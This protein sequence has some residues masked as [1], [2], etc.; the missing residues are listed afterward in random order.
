[1]DVIKEFY[2]NGNSLLVVFMM[3]ILLILSLP[4]PSSW[5][6]GVGR[7]MDPQLQEEYCKNFT[8]GNGRTEFFSPGFPRNY[9]AGIKCF[10]TI[11]ADYG[12]FV[13]VD[14]RDY[15]NIEPPTNEGHCDYDYL[16][17]R[18]GDQGYSPLINKFCGSNFPPIITSSGESLW[19]RFV[20]DGTIEYNGF[21]AVYTFIPNPLENIP[22][23]S[24]CEFEI[25]G[26]T[27]YIGSSNISEE[28]INHSKTHGVP[29]DCTWIIRAEKSK[30]IYLQFPHY[31]L[32]MPNDCNYNFIQVFDGNTEVEDM[33]HNF[34]GSVAEN[35]VS[36]SDVLYVRFVGD[37]KGI[38]SE[39]VAVFTE[40]LKIDDN[41]ECPEHSYDCDDTYCIDES[42]LCNGVRNCRFG[43]DEESC[44]DG[45]DSIPLDM[46]APHVISIMLLLI[47][48]MIG[49][50]A[51]MIYNLHRKLTVDK[52][53]IIA[54]RKSLASL[55]DSRAT[56]DEAPSPPKSRASGRLTAEDLNAC[57]VPAP[58]G[59]GFPF[60]SRS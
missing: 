39:F 22:F 8:Y 26:P 48:I 50:C 51:G 46:T 53:D 18:D 10:R 34:C 17:I 11:S 41:E 25:G 32:Q 36:E 23:I 20:S 19:L 7:A 38:E 57:Y 27:D 21:R 24:K 59:G 28:H 4:L 1:M 15:F 9:P 49:M 5:A 6:G 12:Y 47:V 56:L 60:N 45:G 55:A 16:E 40:M 35:V 2:R 29:L 30:K 58:P 43:W 42:L 14:F 33:K 3:V 52:E 44:S 31:E 37:E 13:R 54:S